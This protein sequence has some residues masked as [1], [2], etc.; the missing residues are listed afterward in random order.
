MSR[1]EALEASVEDA[2]AVDAVEDERGTPDLQWV[3][4]GSS[5]HPNPPAMGPG[6]Y[7]A[8]DYAGT[9]VG[10]TTFGDEVVAA[11]EVRSPESGIDAPVWT[12]R[13]GVLPPPGSRVTLVLRR[14][15]PG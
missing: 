13:K 12:I 6:E 3:F 11:V 15:G 5:F 7:Y 2:E 9:I 8:A 4:A 14:P 1:P 10:L